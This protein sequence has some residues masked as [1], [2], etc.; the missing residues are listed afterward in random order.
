[1]AELLA[2]SGYERFAQ[3]CPT[4]AGRTYKFFTIKWNPVS[5]KEINAGRAVLFAIPENT[6]GYF[7]VFIT[8]QVRWL[9]GS[10]KP[11]PQDPRKGE[12]KGDMPIP[13]RVPTPPRG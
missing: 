12:Q 10:P 5:I 9:D 4:E 1:L 13:R 3:I 7:A 6:D 8:G 2:F 11:P